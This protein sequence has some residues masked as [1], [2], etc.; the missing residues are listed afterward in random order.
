M[1]QVIISVIVMFVGMVVGLGVAGDLTEQ[2]EVEAANKVEA[3]SELVGALENQNEAFKRAKP[4]PKP[5][6]LILWEDHVPTNTPNYEFE[7][8]YGTD[9]Q[10]YYRATV[11]PVVEKKKGWFG[12]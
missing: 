11:V 5:K 4:E 1:K 8:G 2:Q 9:G 10:V 3:L 7:I 12:R 6:V